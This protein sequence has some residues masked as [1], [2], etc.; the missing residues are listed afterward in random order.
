MTRCTQSQEC[1]PLWNAN[2]A[3]CYANYCK[4]LYNAEDEL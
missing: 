3:N 4:T 1:I 2:Y